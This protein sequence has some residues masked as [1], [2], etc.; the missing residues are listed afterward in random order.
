MVSITRELWNGDF[1]DG[2]RSEYGMREQRDYATEV[3]TTNHG[4][5]GHTS[6]DILLRDAVITGY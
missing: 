6:I 5:A 3:N 4:I 2:G 1:F